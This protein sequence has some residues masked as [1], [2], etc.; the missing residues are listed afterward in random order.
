MKEWVM[1][2]QAQA[3]TLLYFVEKFTITVTYMKLCIGKSLDVNFGTEAGYS[4]WG[5]CGFPHCL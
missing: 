3:P 5:F 4:Y 1:F 2:P